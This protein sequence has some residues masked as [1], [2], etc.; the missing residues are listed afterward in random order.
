MGPGKGLFGKKNSTAGH[1][2]SKKTNRPKSGGTLTVTSRNN[3]DGKTTKKVVRTG[4][5]AMKFKSKK[6]FKRT[7]GRG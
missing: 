2:R 5:P 6:S 7:T 3:S 4:L 1:G